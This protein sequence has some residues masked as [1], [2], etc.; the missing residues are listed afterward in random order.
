A[1]RSPGRW[2]ARSP[3]GRQRPGRRPS[4][5][6]AG[7]P[8]GDRRDARRARREL[9]A[10]GLTMGL[11]IGGTKVAGGVVDESGEILATARREAPANDAARML[12]MILDVV[13]ELHTAYPVEA[14][15]VGAA[16]WIDAD[17]ST[18]LFAPNI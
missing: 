2:P 8:P 18:V 12:T 6:P 17:R 14:V 4:R 11:D 10:L 7:T 16:G 3:R 1:V 9:R 15:G 5:E 13:T